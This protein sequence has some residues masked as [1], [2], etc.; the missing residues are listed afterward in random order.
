MIGEIGDWRCHRSLRELNLRGN[1]ISHIDTGL[2]QNVRLKM[3]DLSENHIYLIT[4]L[5]GLAIEALHLAQNQLRTLRGIED[6][7]NLSVGNITGD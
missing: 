3:L 6:L 7:P 5:E 2:R 4:N 1:F